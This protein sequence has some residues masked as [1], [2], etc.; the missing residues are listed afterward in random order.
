GLTMTPD[1]LRLL[2][3]LLLAA[4][5]SAHVSAWLGVHDPACLGERLAWGRGQLA[6]TRGG[7][8]PMLCPPG[9]DQ[10]PRLPGVNRIDVAGD[11][12]PRFFDRTC[13]RMSGRLPVCRDVRGWI[14]RSMRWWRSSLRP[15]CI[16]IGDTP[17]N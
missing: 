8:R 16:S 11:S 3:D 5:L 13:E 12:C 17:V 6:R 15:A 10:G 7:G 9:R 4:T 14:T 2:Q 1:G